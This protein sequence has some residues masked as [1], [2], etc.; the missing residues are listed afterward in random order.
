MNFNPQFSFSSWE[1]LTVTATLIG[2]AWALLKLFGKTVATT[3]D[4]KFTALNASRDE[5]KDVWDKRYRVTED[6]VKLLADTVSQLSS[7]LN[8]SINDIDR[9]VTT[10]EAELKHIPTHEEITTIRETIARV[11]TENAQQTEAMKGIERNQQMIY[12]WMVSN[13]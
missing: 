3:I 10:M 2:A 9:R 12:Q 5:D 6:N 11:A 13:K 8:R 1:V 4:A 7:S